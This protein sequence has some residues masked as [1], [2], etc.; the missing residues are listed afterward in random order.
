[1]GNSE[2]G[3]LNL[4]AGRI[5]YQDFTRINKAIR[6]GALKTNPV[7]REAFD[8]A[9][10]SQLHFIGLVSD[11]GVHSHQDHLV[12]LVKEAADCGVKDILIHAITDGRDTSPTGGAEYLSAVENAL[13]ASFAKIATVVGRYFA[14]DRDKRWDRSKLAW[15]AIVLGRGEIVVSSLDD[16]ITK[17]Y[18]EGE[19]DEFL[20]PLIF[21]YPNQQRIRDGDVVFFF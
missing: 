11:G 8:C 15:D 20:N 14:M 5:V 18:Q 1:M 10:G 13:G 2:V 7:I 4:G 9:R 12:A 19:T 6:D 17:R 3:H 21:S 16:A